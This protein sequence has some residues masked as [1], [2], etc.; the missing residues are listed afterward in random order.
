MQSEY[1]R[2]TPT[3][4]GNQAGLFSAVSSAFV[5]DVQSKLEPD[6]NDMTA[7][8]MKILIHA[9]NASLF[10]DADPGTIAWTGPP[11]GIVT[12]QV[13]LYASLVTS[14]FAAFVAVLGKQW[15][16]RYIRNHGGST[17]DKSRDRQRKLDGF[18]RWHFHLVIESLPIMLQLAVLLLGCALSRYLWTISRTVAGMILAITL[19]G[20][21]LYAF[22][23]LVATVYYNCPYQTPPSVI[24]RT[25][26]G[27][28][29]HSDTTFARSLRSFATPLP[30]IAKLRRIPRR[31]R[32][33]IRHATRVFGCTPVVMAEAEHIPLATVTAAPARVF[34]DV[35]IDWEVCKAD[36]RCISWVLDSTTDIDVIFSTVRFAADTIWYPEI[37]GALSPHTLADLFF[38]CLLDG[39]IIP[40]KSEHAISTG[41]ALTSVLT[42]QLNME[43]ES[44]ALGEIC[45]RLQ[46]R[47]RW[48]NSST[49]PG[50]TPLSILVMGALRCV[51][52]S[53]SNA[54][55]W[56]RALGWGFCR[57]APDQLSTTHKLWFTRVLLQTL[58][59]YQRVRKPITELWIYKVDSLFQK[60][61]ADD[62]W[63]V[64]ILRTNCFL[65]AAISLGL[66]IDFRDLY[67][68]DNMCAVLIHCIYLLTRYQ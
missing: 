52:G 32:S 53:L 65:V 60:F 7:A 2:P 64:G 17:A 67:A 1:T 55:S 21:A 5:I 58:W 40:G 9:V 66:Q 39:N 50:S 62:G 47:V 45:Q 49:G 57:S 29:T 34:E 18:E 22:L 4:E 43:P 33:G 38:D 16:N 68:P 59:R 30:S 35:V 13:L 42:V 28:L 24:T 10:P 37:A 26:I 63:N 14:L 41:M 20:V 48:G 27:Y 19:F 51:A 11:P 31:L 36:V 23:T 8:Y 15:I 25:I 46:D 44:E 12:V 54:P 56:P 3:L 6:P 61:M